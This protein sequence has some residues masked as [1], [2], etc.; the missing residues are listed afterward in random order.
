MIYLVCML[1]PD[2]IFS[3]PCM[4]CTRNLNIYHLCFDALYKTKVKAYKRSSWY[5]PRKWVTH[6]KKSCLP[7]LQTV[8]HKSRAISQGVSE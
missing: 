7:S 3:T 5:V 1:L 4:V 8:A 2:T 6:G